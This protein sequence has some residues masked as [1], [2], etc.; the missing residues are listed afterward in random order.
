ML[1]VVILQLCFPM[2]VR[3]AWFS[4]RIPLFLFPWPPNSTCFSH[5]RQMGILQQQKRKA[6]PSVLPLLQRTRTRKSKPFII[7]AATSVRHSSGPFGKVC[8]STIKKHAHFSPRNKKLHL[9]ANFNESWL[10]NSCSAPSWSILSWSHGWSNISQLSLKK[11]IV[12]E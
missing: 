12:E 1:R 7:M 8:P 3:V 2:L 11:S 5:E 9:L 6:R 10:P 4:S